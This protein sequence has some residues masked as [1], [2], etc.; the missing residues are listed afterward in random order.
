MA[1]DR[2]SARALAALLPAGAFGLSVSLASADAAATPRSEAVPRPRSPATLQSVCNP[3]A[4]RSPMHVEQYAKDGEPFVAVDPETQL[5][6]WGNG[7]WRNGG[8]AQRR[9][10]LGQWRLA[11]RRL[12]QW[13][14]QR[15]AELVSPCPENPAGPEIG[16]VVV[17]PTAFCNINCTY[18]Y[19]PD[20]NNKHVIAQSTVTRLFSEVFASGWACPEIIV[21]WHAGEPMAAPVSFYR[22]A[23][24]TIERLRPRIG[25]REALVP[26]QRHAGRR[27]LV[28]AVPGMERRRRREHRRAARAARPAPQDAQ[29][30]GH[31]R[32]DDGRHPLPQGQ[33]VP[34]HVLSV[35]SNDS[36]V[37]A[38]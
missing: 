25:D 22:E 14:A 18:C 2:R 16:M 20:R 24:A 7:G 38:R 8:W 13:L 26:D 4:L 5:A 12:G 29:R 27:R 1:Q 9:L 17:Q 34:F 11:Q 35:L 30:Q 6:W 23:F 19:L 15:L 10:A 31:V 32:Q 21:L 36:L 3:S 33:R 37:D 28:P